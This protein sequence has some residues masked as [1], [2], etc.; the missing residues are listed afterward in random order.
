[1]HKYSLENSLALKSAH[2]FCELLQSFV[3]ELRNVTAVFCDGTHKCYCSLLG[4]NSEMLLQSF[5]T[6]PRNV[7]TVFCDGDSEMLLQS[8]VTELINITA[9]FCDGTQKFYCSLL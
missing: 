3:T 1:M 6:K 9:V 5:V 8:F 2:A 4:R 7:T